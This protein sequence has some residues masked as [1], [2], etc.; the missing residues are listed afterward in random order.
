MQQWELHVRDRPPRPAASW[1]EN[2]DP[3]AALRRQHEH[4][5]R[6]KALREHLILPSATPLA[7]IRL[8]ENDARTPA[9]AD[10]SV[11]PVA[12]SA[13]RVAPPPDPFAA[14]FAAAMHADPEPIGPKPS[15][16]LVTPFLDRLTREVTRPRVRRSPSSPRWTR[17]G[18][19]DPSPTPNRPTRHPGGHRFESRSARDPHRIF[20]SRRTPSRARW[21]ACRSNRLGRGD[22]R[23]AS[24]PPKIYVSTPT[25]RRVR[26][27]YRD[28]RSTRPP[29]WTKTRERSRRISHPTWRRSRRRGARRMR[30]RAPRDASFAAAPD[31]A[32][33][34]TTTTTTTTTVRT[35]PSSSRDRLVRGGSPST[36]SCRR[37]DRVVV[38]SEASESRLRR[39]PDVRPALSDAEF[40]ELPLHFPRKRGDRALYEEWDFLPSRLRPPPPRCS[41]RRSRRR[42]VCPPR[43]RRRNHAVWTSSRRRTR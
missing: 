42:P 33:T 24:S 4:A 21:G 31:A 43:Q 23:G 39:R 34:T 18:T 19:V 36:N 35:M 1:T 5:A 7:P 30:R 16:R 37:G 12:S 11:A 25:T 17:C 22:A 38:R 27:R 40:E 6:Q 20:S 26:R 32:K 14:V 3:R 9:D 15:P 28:R 13:A 8:P 29:S 2:R 10:D 41:A